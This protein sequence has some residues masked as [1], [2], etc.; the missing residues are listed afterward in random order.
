MHDVMASD[1][2]FGGTT[3]APSVII[4]S[5]LCTSIVR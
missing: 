2:M 5:S 4:V 1:S 3:L